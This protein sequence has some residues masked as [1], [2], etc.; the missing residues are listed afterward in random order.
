[1]GQLVLAVHTHNT[2]NGVSPAAQAPNESLPVDNSE[3]GA[4]CNPVGNP[5][6]ESRE[7]KRASLLSKLN[8]QTDKP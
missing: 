7:E 5:V 6:D 2:R 8:E 3:Q 4:G 1:M